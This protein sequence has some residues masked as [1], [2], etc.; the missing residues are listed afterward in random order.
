MKEP[1]RAVALKLSVAGAI[2]L[3]LN[4]CG[5]RP[6]KMPPPKSPEQL[7]FVRSADDVVNA[8]AMFIPQKES[9]KP[10]A[11]L[12]IHGWGVNFYSPGYVKI[13]RALAERGYTCI[14]VN[15]RMHD[16]GNILGERGGKRIRGGGYWGVASD[17]VRDIAA[18][19]DFAAAQGFSQ[20]VLVGHSAGWG[21]VRNYQL[22]KQDA[23]V[24]GVV[25]ASGAVRAETRPTD[26]DQL[27]QATRLIGESEPDALIRDPKR[28]FPSYISAATFMD[29]T[30]A[31]PESKDFFGM[32]TTNAGVTRLRCPLLAFFGTR[33][34]GIGTEAELERMK[35]NIIR[36][37]T[38]PSRIDTAMIQSADH[39][40]AGEEAQVAETIAKWVNSL[41]PTQGESQTGLEFTQENRPVKILFI[42]RIKP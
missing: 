36:L 26:P 23:R 38:G 22:D 2:I 41:F 21:A 32:Q 11:V 39:M 16:L 20:V 8:G 30:N 15:T 10:I 31:R 18:W 14:T 34:S 1:G 24:V 5:S 6:E 33:E 13:G 42:E 17:E 4:G 19:M 3:A 28:S 37:Q 12:W 7:V 29:I 35:S 40:Y 25:L 9:A 27:V